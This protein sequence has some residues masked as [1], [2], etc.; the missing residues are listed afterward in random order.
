MTTSIENLML[1]KNQQVLNRYTKDYPNNKLT[2]KE[3]F[4]ELMK[5]FWL[6]Q[7]HKREEEVAPENEELKFVCA[8]H[9]EMKEIDDM[10]HTFLLFTKDYMDF[11]YDYFNEYIHHFPTP[12]NEESDEKEFEVDFARYLSYIYDNLGEETVKLWFKDLLAEAEEEQEHTHE[13]EIMAAG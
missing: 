11:G 10:W 8:I 2:S 4:T 12:D 13:C 1:Y 3:A 7:T 6:C 9:A 5:Y